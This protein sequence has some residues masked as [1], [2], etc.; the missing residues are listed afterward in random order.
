MGAI[1][2]KNELHHLYWRATTKMAVTNSSV[3]QATGFEIVNM[4]DNNAHTSFMNATA[5]QTV[6]LID[7]LA[8][9]R[10]NGFAVYGHNLTTGM[11]LKLEYSTD[12]SSYNTFTDSAVYSGDGII[13]PAINNGEAFCCYLKGTSVN[14]RYLKITTS[15]FT[16]ATFVSNFALGNFVDNVN[17]SAPYIMPSFA[18]HE[19]SIKRNNKGNFLSSDT[20]KVPQKLNIKLNTLQESDLDAV[21]TNIT[22]GLS[23]IDYLGFYLT[24]FP[25]FVLLDD[26]GLGTNTEKLADRNKIYFATIDKSLRQPTF[27]TPTTLSWS[28]N[29]IGYIS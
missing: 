16:T 12:N 3:G 8:N 19:V 17:I 5:T 9:R 1:L 23:F 28:I 2:A 20:R 25:F 22:D 15:G 29:A 26:G 4:F 24:R 7:M 14:A 27:S 6:I 13:H 10:F 11:G 21:Q 18:T